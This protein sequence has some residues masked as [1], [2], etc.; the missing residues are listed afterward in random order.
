MDFAPPA[1]RTRAESIVPMI[2]VVFLLLVFFLMTATIAPPQPF[3][4]IPPASRDENAA[5]SDP[6]AV[7]ALH[8]ADDGSL[9]W[10]E[11]RGAS[12]VHAAASHVRAKGAPLL[13]RAD[14][15]ADGAAI[16]RLLSELSESGV[17]QARL[18]TEPAP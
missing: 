17:S 4:T 10:R 16:A 3:E 6:A 9:A 5:Q 13:I 14:R 1:R 7:D 8:V 2:N 11:T 18:V 15:R 12:A